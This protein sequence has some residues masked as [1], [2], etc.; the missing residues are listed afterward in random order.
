MEK[1]S[2]IFL[3]QHLPYLEKKLLENDTLKVNYAFVKDRNCI[4]N[5]LQHV[6]SKYVLSFDLKDFFDTVS[7]DHVRGIID[8]EVI[9]NCFIDGAPRQGLPTSP[10]IATIAFLKCDAEINVALRKLGVEYVYTRYADDLTVSYDTPKAEG[11]I[12][13]L[14]GQLVAKNGFTINSQK[15]KLQ[16][17]KNGRMI[18][19]GVGIDKLGVHPSRK[20]L[21]KIRAAKHQ[22][23]IASFRGLSEWA[24]CK[25]PKKY[26]L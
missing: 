17:S 21:K 6:G 1:D 3:R 10:L 8:E 25:L 2:C 13:F 7:V 16:S 20:T 23:N 12:R 19:T 14:I 11:K 4:L 24:K 22:Y 9:Q 18:V 15:T 5:A 26:P